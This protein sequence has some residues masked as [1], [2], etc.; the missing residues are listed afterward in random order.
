ME[1]NQNKVTLAPIP[2]KGETYWFYLCGKIKIKDEFEAIVEQV[3]PFAECDTYFVRQYYAELEDIVE[4][5]VM[6]IWLENQDEMFWLLAEMTD[7]IIEVS[8]PNLTPAKVY[9]A[10]TTDGEWYSL[11]VNTPRHLG[12]LDVTGEYHNKLHSTK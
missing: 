9:F 4:T 5:A 7:Y 12:L 3:I 10:R 2:K 1:N 8:I 6:D 11:E